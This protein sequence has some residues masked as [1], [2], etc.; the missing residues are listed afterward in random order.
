MSNYI[1]M[2]PSDT[3]GASLSSPAY[4]TIDDALQGAKFLLGNGA[5]SAWIVDSHGGILLPAE[6]VLSRL[7]AANEQNDDLMQG[8]R[9]ESHNF[10]P[11]LPS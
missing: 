3:A 11:I 6:Q 7:G 1:V 4:T 9:D 10:Q 2:I 8:N 5:V